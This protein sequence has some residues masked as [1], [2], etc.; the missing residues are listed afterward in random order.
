MCVQ[1]LTD[2]DPP[3]SCF[4]AVTALPLLTC[5]LLLLLL[6]PRLYQCAQAFCKLA[7]IQVSP[8]QPITP[9]ELAS[10]PYPAYQPALS[11]GV[12]VQQKRPYW[13]DRTWTDTDV[14]YLSFFVAM[15]VIALVGAPLTFSWDALEVMLGG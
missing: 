4:A 11:Q 10:A 8:V 2:K 14:G 5:L 6:L 1:A 12:T 9:E 13:Q 3:A 15:H 7:G